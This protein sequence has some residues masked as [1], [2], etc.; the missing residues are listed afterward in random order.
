MVV[1]DETVLGDS[2]KNPLMKISSRI[3]IF[4]VNNSREE[5]NK[6]FL[7]IKQFVFNLLSE[8]KGSVREISPDSLSGAAFEILSFLPELLS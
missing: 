7:I 5:L 6:T 3:C 8:F 2:D 1:S 4:C